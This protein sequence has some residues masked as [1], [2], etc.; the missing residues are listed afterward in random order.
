MIEAF[1]AA[2]GKVRGET[3]AAVASE[4][5]VRGEGAVAVGN[6]GK[7]VNPSDVPL[8]AKE[9]DEEMIRAVKAFIC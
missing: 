7:Q 9:K 4:L 5:K 3:A 2:V 8:A 1:L 6:T